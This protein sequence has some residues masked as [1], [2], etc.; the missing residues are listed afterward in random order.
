MVATAV[1]RK[2]NE[3]EIRDLV[4]TWLKASKEKDLE[5]MLDLLADDV[6]F[7]VVGKEPFGKEAF[8]EMN[9][10]MKDVQIEGKNEIQEIN[11]LGDWAWMRSFLTVRFI[12][13]GGTPATAS[14]HV[15]TILHRDADAGW[16]IARDANLLMPQSEK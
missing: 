1:D 14:G 4:E 9:K 7:M 16:V 15:L 6:I 13:P 11:V 2:S 3:Q 5:T 8:A 12:P 10:G